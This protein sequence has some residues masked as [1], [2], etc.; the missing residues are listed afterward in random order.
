MKTNRLTNRLL[1]LLS[2]GALL[3]NSC[4]YELPTWTGTSSVPVSAGVSYVSD[5]AWTPASY[6]AN[7]FPIYGYSYG[8]PVYGYTAEGVAIFTVAALTAACLVPLWAPAPWYHGHWHYPPHIHR[9]AAPPRYPA[10]H[11]PAVRPHGGIDA[12]IHR[13]PHEVLRPAH[14]PQPPKVNRPAAGHR[15]QPP[16]MNRPGAEHRPQAPQMNR[17]SAEHRPQAPQMNRPAAEHRP[18][19]PQMHRPAAEHRPQAPQ[20]NRPAAEHRPQAPKMNRPA[21]QHHARRGEM[22][23]RRSHH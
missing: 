9:V 14:R 10:G 8:R 19:A 22:A 5:A 17:P 7:G 1:A 20:M 21:V 15:P 3:L 6:D 4:V 2:C 23:P 11:R 18:Q 16:K 13:R 12:P